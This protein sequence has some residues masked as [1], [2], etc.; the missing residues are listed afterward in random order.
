MEPFR[1]FLPIAA[2]S[3]GRPLNFSKIGRDSGVDPKSVERYFHVL[4]DTLLGFF[5]DSYSRSVRKKQR[6]AP[7]FF[8]FDVGVQR[9]LAQSLDVY[10]SPRTSYYGELF[11][12]FLISE[13][14]RMASYSNTDWQM[15]YLQTSDNLEID[16]LLEKAGRVHWLIEIKSAENVHEEDLRHLKS[17]GKDFPQAQR[18]VLCQEA[19]ERVISDGI[20]ILPW[21]EGICE[22]LGA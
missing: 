19:E 8:F 20:R 22:I 14:H 5:L 13:I 10:P 17:V 7:K 11:E 18:V 9:A 2:L 3:A 15:S 12:A 1:K 4:A 6:H 16:L 21:K